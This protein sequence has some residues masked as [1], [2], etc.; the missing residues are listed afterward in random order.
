MRTRLSRTE[1]RSEILK[2]ARRLIVERGL[3]AT[4]MEDIR[5]A[6]GISRGGLYHHFANKRAVLD[7]LVEEEVSLLADRLDDQ[8]Q[9]PIPALLRAGSGHLGGDVG[10]LSALETRDEKL[11]YL[12]ALDQAF[13]AI[14]RDA[15]HRRITDSV[16]DDINP[17]HV[18]E[19]FLTV[20]AQINRR[21]ILGD[22]SD[23]DAAGF[24]ATALTA[25]A[26][27]LK[28]PGDL[29]PVISDLKKRASSA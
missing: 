24:A 23:P 3:S 14:L 10:V 13:S 7:A 20:N 28:R 12:S 9:P 8:T 16:R 27:L 5:L 6:C 19:L 26:P 29:Y 1:R 17:E 15:L 4:E 25:L 18:A 21:A 2:Q 11:D 22:W